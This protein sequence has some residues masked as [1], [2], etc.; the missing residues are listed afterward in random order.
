MSIIGKVIYYSTIR[1]AKS[2]IFSINNIM[3]SIFLDKLVFE[4]NV[5]I[6]LSLQIDNFKFNVD[7]IPNLKNSNE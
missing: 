4:I 5:A 6:I 3:S 2:R 1:F 7:F